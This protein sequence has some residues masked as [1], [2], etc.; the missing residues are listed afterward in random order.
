MPLDGLRAIAILWVFGLHSLV[1]TGPYY[2]PC[3]FANPDDFFFVIPLVWGDLGVDIF[4]VLSGFLIA[5]VLFREIKKYG[6]IDYFNFV[7]SRFLRIWPAM[8]LY[9]LGLFVTNLATGVSWK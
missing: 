9:C 3:I 8:A 7:R 2:L 4:F 6:K 5:F 1:L